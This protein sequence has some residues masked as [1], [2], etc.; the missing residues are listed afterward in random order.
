FDAIIGAEDCSK[1]KPHPEPY[2]K[3]IK[4]L[5]VKPENA[6]ALEDSS[7]GVESAKAAGCKCIAMPNHFTLDE[8][9]SKADLIVKSLAEIDEKILGKL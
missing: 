8:D 5:G 9:F 4:K 1:S 6:L 2:L 7:R 3:A